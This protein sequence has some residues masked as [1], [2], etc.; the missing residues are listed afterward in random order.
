MRCVERYAFS[1]H[2]Q[3][4]HRLGNPE[5]SPPIVTRDWGPG[6]PPFVSLTNVLVAL[7]LF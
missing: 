5:R 1:P 2:E 3:G 4:L 6:S 7:I